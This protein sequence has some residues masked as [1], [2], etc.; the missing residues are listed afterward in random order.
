[1]MGYYN[2]DTDRIGWAAILNQP[3][4]WSTRS[5]KHDWTVLG[6]DSQKK[7]SFKINGQAVHLDIFNPNNAGASTGNDVLISFGF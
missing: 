2:L 3:K 4:S 1:M 7:Y 5:A 6:N